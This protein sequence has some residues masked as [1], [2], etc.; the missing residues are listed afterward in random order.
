MFRGVGIRTSLSN[1]LIFLS[2]NRT[3]EYPHSVQIQKRKPETSHTSETYEKLRH[4]LFASARRQSLPNL[5]STPRTPPPMFKTMGSGTHG[6]HDLLQNSV[7]DSLLRK[8]KQNRTPIGPKTET[9]KQE[10]DADAP[11]VPSTNESSLLSSCSASNNVNNVCLL[12]AFEVVVTGGAVTG[13]SGVA[14]MSFGYA[15]VSP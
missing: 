8:Q 12:F 13:S 3:R 15:A 10:Q 5:I 6:R 2:P 11:C 9:R 7:V 4:Q 14:V 1:V